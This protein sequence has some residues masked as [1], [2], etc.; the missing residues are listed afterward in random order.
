MKRVVALALTAVAATGCGSSS[1]H[2]AG[3]PSAIIRQGDAA[4]SKA[5]AAAFQLNLK[6]T[7]SGS[8][9]GLNGTGAA[10]AN[11]PV[12]L[13]VRGRAARGGI[14][15][16]QFAINYSGGSLTGSLLSANGRTGYVQLP[17]LFGPGWHSFSI[18]ST[19]AGTSGTGTGSATDGLDP[20]RWLKD[21]RVSS[22]GGQDT[23]SAAL[24]VPALL[25]NVASSSVP[26]V[27][28]DR[29]RLQQVG[30][31]IKTA[32]GSISYD[33]STH[34]PSKVTAQIDISVPPSMAATANGLKG[35]ALSFTLLLSNWNQSFTVSAPAGATPLQANGLG[36]L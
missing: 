33:G 10:L 35:F 27:S 20:S 25:A 24:D 17:A 28:A 3:S 30:K 4:V 29:A 18:P 19:S 22:S 14:F 16:A 6:L 31:A 8:V 13:A 5:T 11:G 32:D 1:S 9:A 36:G 7:L 2:P 34:L 26:G 15:D 12:S 23:I 21:E